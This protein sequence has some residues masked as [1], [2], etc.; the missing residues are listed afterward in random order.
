[1]IGEDEI[2]SF[3]YSDTLSTEPTCVGYNSEFT[4]YNIYLECTTNGYF[5]TF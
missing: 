2:W 3:D 5:L 1:M 4:D